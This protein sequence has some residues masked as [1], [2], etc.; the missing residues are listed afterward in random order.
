MPHICPSNNEAQLEQ[1]WRVGVEAVGHTFEVQAACERPTVPND[2]NT[3][4]P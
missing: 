1:S 2:R 3:F 4:L